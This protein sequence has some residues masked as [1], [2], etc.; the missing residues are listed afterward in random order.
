MSKSSQ[1]QLFKTYIDKFCAG[2][3]NIPEL[4]NHIVD[5]DSLPDDDIFEDDGVYELYN[6][7]WL[8][9]SEHDRGHWSDKDFA[10][11]IEKIKIDLDNIT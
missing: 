9:L 3:Y 4:K 11:Q 5:I 7:V 6:E 8:L 1:D 10:K 2:S